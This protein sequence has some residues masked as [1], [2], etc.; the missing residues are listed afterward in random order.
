MKEEDKGR[1]KRKK[2]LR[3]PRDEKQKVRHVKREW[4]CV[5]LPLWG[6]EKKTVLGEQ[7]V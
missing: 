6:R 1:L 4:G 7:K 2:R 5:F 3:R